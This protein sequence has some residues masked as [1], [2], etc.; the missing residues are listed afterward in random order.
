MMDLA[1][2]LNQHQ[3]PKDRLGYAQLYAT[4]LSHRRSE[5]LS[6]LEIDPHPGSLLAW[7]EY[8]PAAQIVGVSPDY[9]GGVD[10]PRIRLL[11]CTPS[12]PESV[13]E[14]EHRYESLKFDL[15][16]DAGSSEALPI[17]RSFYAHL[18]PDGLYV[19]EGVTEESQIYKYP[20]LVGCMCQHASYFFV[21]LKGRL[22]VIHN[23][24]LESVRETY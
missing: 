3:S 19:I 6:I 8:F 20:S 4:L 18:K 21:G 7:A 15:I 23:H 12:A 14:F 1:Q 9:M 24:Q 10:H 11:E 16:I 5:P 22:C 17:L 2:V 13:A